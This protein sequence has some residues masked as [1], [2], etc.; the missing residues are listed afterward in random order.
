LAFRQRN[1]SG[2]FT[3]RGEAMKLKYRVFNALG[4]PWLG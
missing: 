4:Q 3:W 1:R 2:T